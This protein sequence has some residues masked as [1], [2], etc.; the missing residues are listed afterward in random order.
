MCFNLSPSFVN[1]W[2]YLNSKVG[3]KESK[4]SFQKVNINY[5]TT[6]I[7]KHSLEKFRIAM[8]RKLG[9]PD[10]PVLWFK[11]TSPFPPEAADMEQMWLFWDLAAP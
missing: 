10:R 5:L 8:A 4:L 11:P 3:L 9:S 2:S 1:I 6:S 7:R